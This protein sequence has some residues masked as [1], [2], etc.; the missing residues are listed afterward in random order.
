M[1]RHLITQHGIDEDGKKVSQ[2]EIDR[3]RRRYEKSYVKSSDRRTHSPAPSAALGAPPPDAPKDDRP[4]PDNT[5]AVAGSSTLAGDQP[6]VED[7]LL[8]SDAIILGDAMLNPGTPTLPLARVE[9]LV[10][11]P[12]GF[13]T[14]SEASRSP[15]PARSRREQRQLLLGL[16]L[17]SLRT[18]SMPSSVSSSPDRP[19]ILPHTSTRAS[20]PAVADQMPVVLPPITLPPV[21]TVEV[22]AV[23]QPPRPVTPLVISLPSAPPAI[24]TTVTATTTTPTPIAGQQSEVAGTSQNVVGMLS[25]VAGDQ[26]VVAGKPPAKAPKS[27]QASGKSA[28]CNRISL[29]SSSTT[30]AVTTRKRKRAAEKETADEQN[31]KTKRPTRSPTPSSPRSSHSSDVLVVPDRPTTPTCPPARTFNL[32][33]TTLYEQ[34]CEAPDDDVATIAARLGRYYNWSPDVESAHRQRLSDIR[35]AWMLTVLG[36]AS[37]LPARRTPATMDDYLDGL[38]RRIAAAKAYRKAHRDIP[39]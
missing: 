24:V 38:D 37:E 28:S 36:E 17:S 13:E 30:A 34:L 22:S 4:L 18:P 9:P 14:I 21:T 16:D 2:E 33:L 31:K 32:P 35:G 10:Q 19:L 29:T 12:G 15:S 39:F 25:A 3:Q 27:K 7:D 23:T 26:P 8:S 6:A 1:T 5:A 11:M 20:T